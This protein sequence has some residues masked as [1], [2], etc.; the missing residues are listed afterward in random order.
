MGKRIINVSNDFFEMDGSEGDILY[1]FT[2]NCGIKGDNVLYGKTV[3]LSEMYNSML[4]DVKEFLFGGEFFN[5]SDYDHSGNKRVT[6][7]VNKYTYKK[8]GIS[9]ENVY[10]KINNKNV[11][12]TNDIIFNELKLKYGIDGIDWMYLYDN[13]NFYTNDGEVLGYIGNSILSNGLYEYFFDK[14]NL[15]FDSVVNKVT[16][17]GSISK[18]IVIKWN[19]NGIMSCRDVQVADLIRS[20]KHWWMYTTG[21]KDKNRSDIRD[22]DVLLNGRSVTE[23]FPMYCPVF[24]NLRMNYTGIDFDGKNNIKKCSEIAG[25]VNMG[26]TWSFASID[27]IDSSKGY[28]YD[29][30]RIISQYANGLKNV[31]SIDQLRMLLKYMDEQNN[32]F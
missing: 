2:G 6:S 24:S 8:Y 32:Y 13:I 5:N 20:Y 4:G 14:Y 28:S 17:D 10:N 22:Y 23:V 16:N 1:S 21:N 29:N 26:E 15:C 18:R 27:R 30:I 12:I 3:N 25:N 19:F 7:G 31:G 11:M 9:L